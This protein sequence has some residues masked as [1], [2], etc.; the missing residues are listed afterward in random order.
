[1]RVIAQWLCESARFA[2]AL[3]PISVSDRHNRVPK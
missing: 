2:T 1:L 3:I